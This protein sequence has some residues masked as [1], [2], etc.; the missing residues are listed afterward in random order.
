MNANVVDFFGEEDNDQDINS[1][2]KHIKET[3]IRQNIQN[4]IAYENIYKVYLYIN[5]MYI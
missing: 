4:Y 1:Y 5:F 2:N 3:I